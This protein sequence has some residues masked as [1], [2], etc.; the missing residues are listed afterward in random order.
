MK[1]VLILILW[2]W[3]ITPTWVNVIGTGAL[4]ACMVWDFIMFA[5]D[6]REGK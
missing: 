3:G 1:A 6:N 5:Y 4:S 2:T